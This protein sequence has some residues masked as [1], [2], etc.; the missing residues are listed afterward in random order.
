MDCYATH[1]P[2]Q[3]RRSELALAFWILSIF[4]TVGSGLWLIT[5]IFQPRWGRWIS[6]GGNLSPS[7]ASLIIAL[8]AKLIETSFVAVFVASVGQ[9]LTKRAFDRNSKGLTLAEISMRNWV[10]V[11]K[12]PVDPNMA[13][14]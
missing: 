4:S 3:S 13:R 8:I 9:I 10:I 11:S 6:S 1:D 7:T 14:I 12:R 5:A 2:R